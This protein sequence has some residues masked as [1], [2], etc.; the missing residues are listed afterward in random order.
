MNIALSSI[1]LLIAFLPG[2]AF[3][4]MYL[5]SKFSFKNFS[6]NIFEEVLFALIPA[7]IFQFIGF[8]VLGHVGFFSYSIDF[9][10]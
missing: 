3:R 8:L 10:R 4:R 6:G 2:I 5:S 9:F 1:V 7:S